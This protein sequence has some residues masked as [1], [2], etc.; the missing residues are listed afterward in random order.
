M[1]MEFVSLVTTGSIETGQTYINAIRP[2]LSKSVLLLLKRIPG[3]RNTGCIL[4]CGQPD[5]DVEE[6]IRTN[7]DMNAVGLRRLSLSLT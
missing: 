7:E 4:L 5:L 2:I 6:S 3:H 1:I